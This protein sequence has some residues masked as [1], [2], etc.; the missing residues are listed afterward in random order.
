MLRKLLERVKGIE[1]SLQKP[2]FLVFFGVSANATANSSV[3]VTEIHKGHGGLRLS[4]PG[5]LVKPPLGLW[6]SLEFQGSTGST[7]QNAK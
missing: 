2:M 4:C 5:Q 7:Q 1:P 6:T 3:D